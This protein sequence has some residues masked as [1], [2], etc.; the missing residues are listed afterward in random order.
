MNLTIASNN[1]WPQP[2]EDVVGRQKRIHPNKRRTKMTGKGYLAFVFPNRKRGIEFTYRAIS[3]MTLKLTKKVSV[4]H[5][6]FV[7]KMITK[8]A[9]QS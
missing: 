6:G 2:A 8:T 1:S 5:L 7:G 4:S 9:L 3:I